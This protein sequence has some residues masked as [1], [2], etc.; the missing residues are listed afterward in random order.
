M[1]IIQLDAGKCY[2]LDLDTNEVEA[3]SAEEW[4]A[5]AGQLHAST[6]I[7][8]S[9]DE[10]ASI[11][12]P[13]AVRLVV[14]LYDDEAGVGTGY[15]LDHATPRRYFSAR[16]VPTLD[17]EDV[18]LKQALKI[19]AQWAEEL[20]AS[21]LLF[22]RPDRRNRPLQIFDTGDLLEDVPAP[23]EPLFSIDY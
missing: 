15:F 20:G 19:G 13:H 9:E 5:V 3:V 22:Y 2:R 4:R 16:P 10:P 6:V 12:G 14:L 7:S 1:I 11:E 8:V 17:L 23:V 18:T 21:Q